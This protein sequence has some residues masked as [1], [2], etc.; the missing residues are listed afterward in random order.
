MLIKCQLS[1]KPEEQKANP[2]GWRAGAWGGNEEGV[3]APFGISPGP[4]L[5]SVGRQ[6]LGG[7]SQG[8]LQRGMLPGDFSTAGRF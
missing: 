1:D 2:Q 6:K 3:G 7:S 5:T 4:T 8:D